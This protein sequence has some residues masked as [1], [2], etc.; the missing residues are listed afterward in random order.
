MYQNHEWFSPVMILIA[1]TKID[2]DAGQKEISVKLRLATLNLNFEA[3]IEGE[4]K[5]PLN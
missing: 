1:A 3:S 4:R 5:R 2:T